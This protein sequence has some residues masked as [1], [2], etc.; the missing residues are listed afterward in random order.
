MKRHFPLSVD[1]EAFE[2]NDFGLRP[3]ISAAFAIACVDV[4]PVINKKIAI[5]EEI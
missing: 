2:L 5:K 4:G 3:D 1:L